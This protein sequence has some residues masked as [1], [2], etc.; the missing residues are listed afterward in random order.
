MK[1]VLIVDDEERYLLSIQSGFTVYK[2]QLNIITATNGKKAIE[3]LHSESIDLVITDLKMP[4]MDGFELLA[5]IASH[6]S[7]IPTIVM[8]AFGTEDVESKIKKMGTLKLL[9]KPIDFDQLADAIFKC[10]ELVTHEGQL[11]GI[12]LASFLQII[13]M[14][15]KSCLLEI[16]GAE[17]ESGLFYF[18]KGAPYSAIYKNMKGEAAALEMLKM[19]AVKIS[20]RKTPAR[21]FAKQISTTLMSLLMDVAK[22]KDDAFYEETGDGESDEIENEAA[23]AKPA[24]QHAARA[25]SADLPA[26]QQTPSGKKSPHKPQKEELEKF[27][28]EQLEK[29]KEVDGFMAVGVFSPQGE[30][31]NQVNSSGYNMKKVGAY[32][33]EILLKTQQTTERI[34]MGKSQMIHIA[35]PRAQI[36]VRCLNEVTSAT[37][38]CATKGSS[39][40]AHIHMILI[41]NADSNITIGKMKLKAVIQE[42]VSC[43]R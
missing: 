35:A 26:T 31:A 16:Q 9:E 32:V 12:S 6:F 20:I 8:T 27:I 24:T 10:L 28:I 1:N 37:K 33:N 15:A 23:D 41:L 29:F 21:K 13:E 36:V 11:T 2:D 30:L 18:H 14:E 7:S 17:P 19:G 22:D 3:V 4:E 5:Y 38:A 42:I 34:G 25:D 43:Y 39:G 40:S